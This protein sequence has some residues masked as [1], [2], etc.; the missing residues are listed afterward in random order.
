M[1][2]VDKTRHFEDEDYDPKSRTESK[3]KDYRR[4]SRNIFIGNSNKWTYE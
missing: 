1:G 4:K 3:V 2:K